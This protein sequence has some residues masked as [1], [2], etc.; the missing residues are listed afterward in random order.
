MLSVMV[1][2][3]LIFMSL[4]SIDTVISKVVIPR[5]QPLEQSSHMSPNKSAKVR[6]SR[7]PP[8]VIS[9]LPCANKKSAV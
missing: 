4:D 1:S 9:L 8:D 2:I 5:L 3:E 7:Q 6:R